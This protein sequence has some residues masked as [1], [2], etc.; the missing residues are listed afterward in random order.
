MTSGVIIFKSPAVYPAIVAVGYATHL[1][2][3]IVEK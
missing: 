1:I 3:P 2:T